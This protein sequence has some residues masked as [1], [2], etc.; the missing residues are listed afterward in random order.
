[1]NQPTEFLRIIGDDRS[2]TFVPVSA[3]TLIWQDSRGTI[4]VNWLDSAAEAPYRARTTI[5]RCDIVSGDSLSE[6]LKLAYT[7][8]NRLE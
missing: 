5:G 8:A 3:I 7:L 2:M 1:M 4:H 6:A